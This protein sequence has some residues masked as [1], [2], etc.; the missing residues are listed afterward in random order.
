METKENEKGRDGASEMVSLG[1]KK[2]GGS[3]GGLEV[4]SAW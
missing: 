1:Q 4:M 2:E 3:E